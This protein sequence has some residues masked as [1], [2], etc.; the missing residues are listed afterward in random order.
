M[1]YICLFCVVYIFYI[2]VL[3]PARFY[4]LSPARSRL[5]NKVS[6][7]RNKLYLQMLLGNTG[8]LVPSARD[9]CT[10]SCMLKTASIKFLHIFFCSY[11]LYSD[12]IPQV[13]FNAFLRDV[14][15]SLRLCF[16]SEEMRLCSTQTHNLMLIK[17]MVYVGYFQVVQYRRPC[18]ANIRLGEDVLKTS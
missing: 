18:P 5:P 14:S 8:L 2:S 6:A 1:I 11:F 3:Q 16:D 15:L 12:G 13:N 4:L 7:Y 9:I 10:L 17:C